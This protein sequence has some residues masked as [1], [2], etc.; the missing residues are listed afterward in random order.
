MFKKVLIAEDHEVRNLGIINS[1]T[2]LQINN[3][4]FVSYCDDAIQKIKSSIAR[5]DPYDL[6]ITDLSFEKDHLQQ[7]LKSGQELIA[8]AKNFHPRLKIIAFSI[9]KKPKIIDDLFKISGIN[10]FVSKARNDGKELRNTI[11][12]VFN[13]E[14]VIPQEILNAIRN[15]PLEITEKDELLLGLLAKGFSQSEIEDHFKQHNI[16]PNSRSSIEKILKDLREIF[17]AKN[18]IE[19]VAICKD[20]GIL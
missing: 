13:G 10:G 8:E 14:T 9:E 12:K 1:L 5:N 19:M 20:S 3:Y 7:N 6:L 2:D 18:N 16:T 15:T 17:N 11:R 4:D